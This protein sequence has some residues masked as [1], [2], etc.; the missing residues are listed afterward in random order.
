M[1]LASRGTVVV[2]SSPNERGIFRYADYL[3]RLTGGRLITCSKRA[4]WFIAWEIFGVVRYAHKMRLADETIFANTRVS[5]LLWLIIDWKRV[6]VV[7]HDVM[8]TTADK[9][10]Y[11]GIKG[12]RK[13]IAICVNSWIIQNS[14]RRAGKV[15]F[16]SFYTRSQVERWMSKEFSRSAVIF[17]PPSFAE[18]IG[19]CNEVYQEIEQTNIPMILVVTG[20]T[21]NK[22]CGDYQ[23]FYEELLKKTGGK[24]KLVLYGIHV[25][26]A[27]DGFR[28]WIEANQ[29]LVEVKYKREACELYR[30]YLSCSLVC[31]L[32]TEEG[33]G[34][35]VADALGFGIPVVARSI[36]AYKEIKRTLDSLNL[37]RLGR[38]ID[39][40]IGLATSLICQYDWKQEAVDR[41]ERYKVFCTSSEQAARMMLVERVRK[42]Q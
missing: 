26:R 7:V 42:G 19:C 2:C 27:Q 21:K 20:M 1:G 17:P 11:G 3:S 41:V 29:G 32:S 8:D 6:T 31:S 10:R 35:P 39:E 18:Q 36:D 5:P 15:V 24:V 22:M 23:L 16:N 28:Q 13:Q 37:L 30:D 38:D 33:Y 4:S 12:V 14:V 40:C 25:D 9:A 34:M